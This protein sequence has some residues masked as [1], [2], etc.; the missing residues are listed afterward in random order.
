M[1]Q[2]EKFTEW[3]KKHS[4]CGLTEPLDFSKY[5]RLVDSW[6]ITIGDNT[7]ANPSLDELVNM[8]IRAKF[9]YAI[10]Q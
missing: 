9:L 5:G 6:S 4:T 2:F 10:E 3:V 8:Y 1:K 7:I